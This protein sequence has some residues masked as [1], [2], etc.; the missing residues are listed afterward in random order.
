MSPIISIIGIVIGL[1]LMI[2]LSFKGV[3]IY[4]YAPISAVVVMLFGGLPVWATLTGPYMEGFVGY[5]KNYF[6]L[7]AMASMY[8]KIMGDSGAAQVIA[9]T[10]TNAAKKAKKNKEL[11]AML[12]LHVVTLLLTYGGINLFVVTFL[13]ASIAKT[14][15]EELD[16][17]WHLYNASAWASGTI[18]MTMLPGSPAAQNLIPMQYLGTDAKAAPLLGILSAIICVVLELGYIVYVQRRCKKKGEGFLP[19]GAVIAE[20]IKEVDLKDTDITIVKALIPSIVLL[21]VLNFFKLPSVLVALLVGI[22]LAVILYWK[23]IPNVLQ[24]LT[25]GVEQSI[26]V[27]ISVCAVVGFGSV[28][29]VTPGYAAVIAG[30]DH[31]PGGPLVQL[32]IAVNVCAGFAG[33]ASG[34]LAIGLNSFAQKFLDMGINPQLIHRVSAIASGGLDSLPH[35]G[36]VNS[37]LRI[38]GLTH[39]QAYIH[40]FIECTIIPLIVSIFTLLMAMAGIC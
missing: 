20:R 26:G 24:S 38:A 39:K 8:A 23:N 22:V 4:L 25:Q 7:F 5:A 12:S 13:M 16:I 9:V 35:N 32:L 6:L 30:L 11:V 40:T 27:T 31:V 37:G 28:V 33:S 29:A 19:T 17:P 14:M 18:T 21:I 10:L 2:G 3:S 34:G 15:Y 1:A 36:A